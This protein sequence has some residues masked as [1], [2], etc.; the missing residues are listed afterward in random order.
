MNT[1]ITNNIN[2]ISRR[3]LMLGAATAALGTV[4]NVWA[5]GNAYPNK[6]V[7]IVVPSSPGGSLDAVAR[8][9]AL[10]LADI[11]KQPVVIDNKPG[12][13]FAIGSSFVAK[14][15]AD[16]YTLLYAHDGAMSINPVL[17]PKLSYDPLTELTPIGRVVDLPL[18]V[19]VGKTVPFK[20]VGEFMQALRANPGKFNHASGGTATLMPSELFKAV[21]GV[22]YTD[23][24]YKGGGPAV[25][26]VAAGEAD[27]TFAD[28][29]SASAL[30]QTERIRGL[31]T[32]SP[33]RLASQPNLPSLSET[34]P[35]YATASWSGL[36]APAETPAAIIQKINS[37]MRLALAMPDVKARI[38]GL[39]LE[40]NP[41]SSEELARQI[42]ADI[43]KW[44]KLVK[45]KNIVVL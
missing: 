4:T 11:W 19:Y 6:P 34:V 7:K 32:A 10:K 25:L 13:N 16:G 8:I 3:S 38:E 41:S 1:N 26:A 27:F 14:S 28:P 39:G 9:I 21:S 43:Q 35:E 23:I 18:V 24:P 37:D 40:V 29:G 44:A 22:F 17:Y 31:A 15:P 5:Q 45:E 20:T 30:L 2:A 42:R 12:A 33:K 36:H